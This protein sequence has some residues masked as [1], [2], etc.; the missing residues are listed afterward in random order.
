MI[1]KTSL[2]LVQTR[3]LELASPINRIRSLAV[4]VDEAKG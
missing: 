2:F 4:H 3:L 1:H